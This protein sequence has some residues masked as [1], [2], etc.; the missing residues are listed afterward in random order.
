MSQAFEDFSG[1][2]YAKKSLERAFQ[3]F[4][5]HTLDSVPGLTIHGHPRLHWDCSRVIPKI[6]QSFGKLFYL[7]ASLFVVIWTRINFSHS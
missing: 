6:D 4:T 3:N 1:L 5:S 2:S 7:L